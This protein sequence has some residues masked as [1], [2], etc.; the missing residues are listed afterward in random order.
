[1]WLT[2]ADDLA[3]DDLTQA[4]VRVDECMSCKICAICG[5]IWAGGSW[6]GG[7]GDGSVV[8]S[9][10]E[11]RKGV[12]KEANAVEGASVNGDSAPG[13]GKYRSLWSHDGPRRHVP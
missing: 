10:K 7:R 4:K 6:V 8:G 12:R 2:R 13:Q 1:M 9:S 3:L 11:K 5:G